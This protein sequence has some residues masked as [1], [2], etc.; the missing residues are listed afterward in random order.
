MTDNSMP[1]G[2]STHPATSTTTPSGVLRA[3]SGILASSDAGGAR[4]EQDMAHDSSQHRPSQRAFT[5][6]HDHGPRYLGARAANV[7]EES[8]SPFARLCEW[9]LAVC[10]VLMPVL[11]AWG[12][13]VTIAGQAPVRLL[14]LVFVVLVLIR[15]R[16]LSVVTQGILVVT[17]M[18]MILGLVLPAGTTGVKELLCVAFGLL[19]MAAMTMTADRPGWIVTVCRAWLL[20]L[21]VAIL[22]ALNEVRTGKHLPNYLGGTKTMGRYRE[23]ASFMVNPNLFAYFLVAGMIVM[24]VGW[25]VERHWFVRLMYIGTFVLCFPLLVLAGARLALMSTLVILAW[26]MVRYR[27]LLIAAVVLTLTGALAIIVSGKL[28][29]VLDEVAMSIHHLSSNSGRSRLGVYQDAIWMFV[30]S[31]G[32]GLGP[33]QFQD[34]VLLAPW[35]NRGTIDPHNGFAELFVGYGLL[36]GTVLLAIGIAVLWAGARR[37]WDLDPGPAQRLILQTVVASMLVIPVIALANSSYLK[38]PVVWAQ[39]ATVA[40]FCEFLR[41]GATAGLEKEFAGRCGVDETPRRT[42]LERR[43]RLVRGVVDRAQRPDT[44][45]PDPSTG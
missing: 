36:L 12:S 31:K 2:L 4:L 26:L 32:V 15:R 27:K 16:Y 11:S 38:N 39:M 18:W 41:P 9:L 34:A 5:R 22:P 19:T 44:S 29:D 24:V 21:V 43:S 6:R 17:G 25:T 28:D 3:G 37:L 20:G 7:V 33:G 10:F 8:P 35:P 45:R 23:I 1:S 14:T 40:V 13:T 42:Y 30:A